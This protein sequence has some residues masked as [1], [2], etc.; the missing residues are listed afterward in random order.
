MRVIVLS[1]SHGL[2]GYVE[3]VFARNP[4]A[5]AY[6]FLGDGER[7]IEVMRTRYKS[8]DIR[9]VSGNCDY[10]GM[11]P[12][13]AV[14]EIGG[15]RIY[16]THGHTCGVKYGLERLCENARLNDCTVAL[17]GHTHVK[18]I[19]YEDGIYIMNPGS[20]SCPRDLSKP[21]YGYVDIERN[22]IFLNT[23][24]LEY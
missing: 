18:N 13:A 12:S 23:V 21:S 4:D 1:D 7:D 15:V 22:G 20:C 24:E 11:R 3:K 5:A 19:T 8:C 9:T 16:Y 10:E 14:A 2:T 6:I 17:Y